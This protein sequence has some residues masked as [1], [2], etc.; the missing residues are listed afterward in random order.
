MTYEGERYTGQPD[1]AANEA[2]AVPDYTVFD[3]FA[4]TA[5]AATSGCA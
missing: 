1:T 3:V 5:T 2:M 4:T